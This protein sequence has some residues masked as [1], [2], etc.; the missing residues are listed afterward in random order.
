MSFL[1]IIE[2]L[3]EASA[4]SERAFR[5]NQMKEV[6]VLI[7]HVVFLRINLDKINLSMIKCAYEERA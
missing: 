1:S 7:I 6:C 4:H 5:G 2:H 3:E